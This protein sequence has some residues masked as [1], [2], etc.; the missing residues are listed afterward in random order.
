MNYSIKFVKTEWFE[1]RPFRTKAETSEDNMYLILEH[2]QKF[3]LVI[4]L[5]DTVVRIFVRTDTRELATLSNLAGIEIIATETPKL[6]GIKHYRK[7]LLKRH[8]AL[9]ISPKR[10]DITSI[11]R[12]IGNLVESPAF[13]SLYAKKIPMSPMISSY[14]STLSRGEDAEGIMRYITPYLLTSTPTAKKPSATKTEKIRLAREKIASRAL[15]NCKI[16]IGAQSKMDADSMAGIMPSGAFS[17]RHIKSKDLIGQIKGNVNPPTF[18]ASKFPV[19]NAEE[20]TGFLRFPTNED[21]SSVEF[22]IGKIPSQSSGLEEDT[23][24]GWDESKD[25]IDDILKE[26]ERV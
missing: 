23:M 4:Y 11:Y 10:M 8:C 9:P 26:T 24:E 7:Y 20:I 3:L 22:E 21:I 12:V 5:D 14:I 13:I 19:L 17:S 15:F 1:M 6:H 18:G 2:I 16:T 25:E